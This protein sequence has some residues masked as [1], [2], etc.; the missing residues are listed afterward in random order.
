[1]PLLVAAQDLQPSMRLAE[2]FLWRGR[3]M[4]PGGKRLDEA[5]V[6]VV[7]EKFPNICLRI[8][9]PVLDGLTE[10]EDDRH[11]RQ[12]ADTVRQK[13]SGCMHEVQERIAN[14]AALTSLNFA[15]TTRAAHDI[16]EYL[17]AN[18][19]S[20]ALLDR[21]THADNPLAEHTGTT[22][23]LT[24]V[25]GAAVR[26]Y[27]GQERRRQTRASSLSAD[28]AMNLLPLGLGAM[29]MDIGM[30]PLQ[31]VYAP[32][33]VLTDADRAAI[34]DHC[35]A[36]AEML[37]DNLP[38]GVKMVVR[39]HHENYDGTGYP[40]GTPGEKLHVFTRIVRI[41]DAYAAATSQRATR[42][43]KTTPRAIWEMS[44]GPFRRCYDPSLIR[45]FASL[46]QPF[47]VG[48][49]LKLSDGRGAVVVRYNRVN[50]F[51][52]RV[53]VAFDEKGERLGEGKLK[54]PLELG[55]GND[56]RVASYA[57]E[58][59]SYLYAEGDPPDLPYREP[60]Q[61][62]TLLEAAYP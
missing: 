50:P 18:P 17:K 35:R 11:E 30:F 41:C 60:G 52:P 57:G 33:Y 45:V 20:A 14:H 22:F 48:A 34:R 9:D 16:I 36:G 6:R 19:V 12:V 3:M 7:R 2:A 42:G 39:T 37:P 21:S 61:F 38:T 10:F 28:V 55:D 1:M 49:R 51:R 26:D 27:V 4:L 32:G 5:D 59:L 15:Q 29:F 62:A 53:I 8:A 44:S 24:M 23:Y 25:L 46:I 13:I 58:D 47:P 56:L 54:G 43:A 31:H 40:A